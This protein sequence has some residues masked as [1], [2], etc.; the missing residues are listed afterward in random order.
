MSQGNCTS[1]VYSHMEWL[2][3]RFFF[4]FI[5]FFTVSIWCIVLSSSV[6]IV[7]LTHVGWIVLSGMSG[8]LGEC[9]GLC[10]VGCVGPS[11]SLDGFF[12]VAL[13]L[14]WFDLSNSGLR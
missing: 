7:C 4:P 5:V 3:L 13:F 14:L 6:A 2:H 1:K 9:W 10:A 11:S 8:E 12:D